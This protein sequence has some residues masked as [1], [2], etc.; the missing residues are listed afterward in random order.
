MF[1]NSV[2]GLVAAGENIKD[3]F[4]RKYRNLVEKFFENF[5][6]GWKRLEIDYRNKRYLE[7]RD[8]QYLIK[9]GGIENE[10]RADIKPVK[11]IAP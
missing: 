11:F 9:Q 3:F 5:F 7:I 4:P 10:L 6:H 8:Q 2:S 1:T